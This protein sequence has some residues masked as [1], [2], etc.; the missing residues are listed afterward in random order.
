[1]QLNPPLP[2]P[3]LNLCWPGQE[4]LAEL[5]STGLLQLW[6]EQRL[7]QAI[8][9]Q[10]QWGEQLEVSLQSQ[11]PSL[12]LRLRANFDR[13]VVRILCHSNP[14]LAREWFFR[15]QSQP[16]DATFASLLHHSVHLVLPTPQQQ[17]GH[18]GPFCLGDLDRALAQP[19]R[20]CPI[21]KVLPPLQYSAHPLFVVMQLLERQPAQLTPELAAQ[22]RDQ[23]KKS[24]LRQTLDTLMQAPP[25]PGAPIPIQLAAGLSDANA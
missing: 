12:F 14:A 7:N 22:L 24:W 16:T 25:Q 6:L 17:L 11:I 3:Q 19:L 20:N 10:P 5:Q 23:L 9:A 2:T 18:Y 4:V 8:A 13:V 15:L 1:M 21:G